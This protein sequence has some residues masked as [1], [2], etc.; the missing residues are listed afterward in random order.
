MTAAKNVRVASI[1]ASSVFLDG[2]ATVEK[3][4]GLIEEAAKNGA[5]VIVFPE[6]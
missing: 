1:Q 6:T 5:E 2:K 4:V 3:G